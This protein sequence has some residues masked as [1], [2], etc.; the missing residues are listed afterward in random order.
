MKKSLQKVSLWNSTCL[1]L[2]KTSQK[3]FKNILIWVETSIPLMR[4]VFNRVIM[5]WTSVVMKYFSAKDLLSTE[6]VFMAQWNVFKF[7][8]AIKPNWTY[9]IRLVSEHFI[10][11]KLAWFWS[12]FK[13][14]DTALHWACRGGDVQIV[15]LLVDAGARIN[16]KDKVKPNNYKMVA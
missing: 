6:L 8:F 3:A 4:L 9:K 15:K 1:Q 5:T 12:S 10:V 11:R 13:L 7:L 14:G 16:A 2:L